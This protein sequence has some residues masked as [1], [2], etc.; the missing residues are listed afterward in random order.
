MCPNCSGSLIEHTMEARAHCAHSFTHVHEQDN[1]SKR[2]II[3][4]CIHALM[5]FH[6]P[7]AQSSTL[8]ANLSATS[9][10]LE[11]PYT[12]APIWRGGIIHYQT[13]QN[14]NKIREHQ[15]SRYIIQ[16]SNVCHASRLDVTTENRVVGT[17]QGVDYPIVSKHSNCNNGCYSH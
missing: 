10:F 2:I 1:I 3:Q 4:F 15:E 8:R 11:K 17:K 16:E 7:H 14:K 6:H 5:L 12:H 13:E 9:L